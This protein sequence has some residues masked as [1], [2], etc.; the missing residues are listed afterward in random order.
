MSSSFFE[1]QIG[2]LNHYAGHH[3]SWCFTPEGI[4]TKLISAQKADTPRWGDYAEKLD[5]SYISELIHTGMNLFS[6][7]QVNIQYDF[8]NIEKEEIII[9]IIS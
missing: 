4:R 5:L 9:I 1:N 8:I 3:C 2:Y 7:S 6:Y